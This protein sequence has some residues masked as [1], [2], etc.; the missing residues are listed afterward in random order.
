MLDVEIKSNCIEVAFKVLS[1]PKA[2]SKSGSVPQATVPSFKGLVFCVFPA[3]V[4]LPVDSII[5]FSKGKPE[6]AFS[7]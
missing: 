7:K 1:M 2:A 3:D 5:P 4:A 6:L